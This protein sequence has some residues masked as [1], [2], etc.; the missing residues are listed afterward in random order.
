M[1]TTYKHRSIALLGVGQG[2][3]SLAIDGVRI[4][5]V[6]LTPIATGNVLVGFKRSKVNS[7]NT[8]IKFSVG[9]L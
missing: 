4:F 5:T 1:I 3:K 8:I 6:I 7:I 2:F 9:R